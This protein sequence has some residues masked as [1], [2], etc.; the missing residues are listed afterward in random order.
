MS[1]ITLHSPQQIEAVLRQ[2]KI[3]KREAITDCV[4]FLFAETASVSHKYLSD[5]LVNCRPRRSCGAN[6]VSLNLFIND[7]LYKMLSAYVLQASLINAALSKVRNG[8][9][10]LGD[11]WRHFR[12]SHETICDEVFSELLYNLKFPMHDI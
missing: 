10:V 12:A 9:R 3:R 8:R 1:F 11:D 7:F 4:I 2:T 5:I 6:Q